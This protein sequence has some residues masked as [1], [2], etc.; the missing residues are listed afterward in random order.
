MLLAVVKVDLRNGMEKD[1]TYTF[2]IVKFTSTDRDLR[3]K[4]DLEAF[5]DKERQ[6]IYT[7]ELTQQIGF[8]STYSTSELTDIRKRCPRRY[9]ETGNVRLPT[10]TAHDNLHAF[11][12]VLCLSFEYYQSFSRKHLPLR[13]PSHWVPFRN[14]AH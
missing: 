7:N 13:S 12:L 9:C 5:W 8:Y 3:K 6:K 11:N 1:R 4:C 10:A 2:S 14:A